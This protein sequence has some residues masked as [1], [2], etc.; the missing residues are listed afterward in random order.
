MRLGLG[1]I[2]SSVLAAAVGAAEFTETTPLPTGVQGHSVVQ[3]NGY[4]YVLS[5]LSNDQAIFGADKVYYA[6][7]DAAGDPI[8][9]KRTTD[10]PR[11]SFFQ[12]AVVIRGRVYHLGGWDF[13]PGTFKFSVSDRVLSAPINADGTLGAWREELHLPEP[14]FYLA[15]A[16]S[17]ETLYV[18]GGWTGAFQT[19]KVRSSR[20]DADGR[21]QAWREETPLPQGVHTHSAAAFDRLHAIGGA[22][23]NGNRVSNGVIAATIGADATLGAWTEEE[24][25]LEII[26]QHAGVTHGEEVVV[27]GGFAGDHVTDRVQASV[28]RGDRSLSPWVDWPRLPEPLYLHDA[29]VAGDDLYVIG[30]NNTRGGCARVHRMKLEPLGPKASVDLEPNTLNL[31]SQGKYITAFFEFAPGSLSPADID[32]AS[33]RLTEVDG[34]PVSPVQAESK[35][36]SLG[37]GNGNG[38]Q[39]LMVKFAR[40][41]VGALVAPADDVVLTFAGTAAGTAFT[42]QGAIRTVRPAKAEREQTPPGLELAPGKAAL[43]FLPKR[44][45]TLTLHGKASISVPEGA[46][47][48]GMPLSVLPDPATAHEKN[49]RTR[50]AQ[51]RGLLRASE[52]VEL[53][54]DSTVFG[55]P[56]S[57]TLNYDASGLPA[58]AD[59][60]KIAVFRWNPKTGAWERLDSKVDAA[61]G[62]VTGR[63]GHFSLYQA[64]YDP[65]S[66]AQSVPE[67]G[68]A[69]AYP[70]PASGADSP[71]VQVEVERGQR[72]LV[73]VHDLSGELVHEGSVDGAPSDLGGARGYRYRWDAAGAASGVYLIAV[74]VQ[75]AGGSAHRMVRAAVVR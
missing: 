59:P 62:T 53:G 41:S 35:P 70:N 32:P 36:V 57:I 52:A 4:L 20:P 3:H 49:A 54:P 19:N 28:V 71:T 47:A 24:P 6:K 12:D 5:G 26:A 7:L 51:E 23:D 65:S 37:D 38:A 17:G 43:R 14:A 33:L 15:A 73:R 63:T 27:I 16:V 45:G 64:Q 34:A 46:L 58:G 61:A 68:E 25:L 60:A 13:D 55:K 21:L 18:S 56:V 50:A 8:E 29:A 11:L 42:A 66:S 39:D 1:I 22:V 44:G 31:T 40:A 67:I 30:G 9:W 2:V 74:E 72:M 75:G 69:F 48:F 10:L